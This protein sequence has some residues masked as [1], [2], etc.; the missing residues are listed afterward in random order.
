MATSTIDI[1][2]MTCDHCVGS[3]TKILEV[4]DGVSEVSVMLAENNAQV[5]YDENKVTLLQMTKAI[6]EDG[7]TV[8]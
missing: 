3:I 4:F 2:G 7:Y 6:E 8:K 5:T 1:E